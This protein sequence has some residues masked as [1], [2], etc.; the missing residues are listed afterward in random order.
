[1][2]TSVGTLLRQARELRGLSS[3][4]TAR[5]ALI[6]PA[7]LNKLEN[8]AVRRPSPDVLHRLS[9]VLEVPYTELMALVGYPMPGLAEPPHP[10]RLG[11]A[12]FAD[13]TD[14]ERDEL[15]EYLAWYRAR[16]RSRGRTEAS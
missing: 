13:L 12:L 15:L 2:S 7:Y 1:M 3:T 14:D 8:D 10:A 16:K 11:A 6:S 4:E 5:T 9:E